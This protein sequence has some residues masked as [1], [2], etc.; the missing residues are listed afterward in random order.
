M[1]SGYTV[2]SLTAYVETNK[3][4]LIK[5]VVLGGVK[6]DT[7]QNCAKQLGVKE[8]ERLNFLN[9]DPVLQDGKGCGFSASGNTDFTEREIECAIIK[10]ND[11][12]CPD[13][14][15]DK[16][17]EYQVRL[18]ANANAENMPFEE[19]ILNGI[20]EKIAEKMEK[21]VWQGSK[22]SGDLIDGFLTQATT[23][24]DSGSTSAVTIATGTSVYDAIGLVVANLPEVI[25][26]K[27][28]IF[29]APAIYRAYIQDLVKKNYYHYDPANGEPTD[30]Y[31]PGTNVKVHKT[32]GLMGD[33]THIYA[34]VWENMAYGTDLMNDKEEFRLWFSDDD[35]L[36]KLK[37]KWNAGVK[38]YFPDVVVVGTASA[39]LV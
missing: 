36:F 13:D 23:G 5:G 21:L 18:G 38:T 2:S 19:E 12:W 17:A 24:A 26:D 31:F 34:N 4:V 6:G 11:Q 22:G 15:L 16:F 25:A 27:A 32:I 37:V 28:Y 3:D 39:N 29:V 33:K 14:L 30:M 35:D 1:A 7:I 20:E 10:V 8:K 9:V